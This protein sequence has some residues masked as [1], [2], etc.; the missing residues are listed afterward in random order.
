MEEIIT[1]IEARIAHLDNV[2]QICSDMKAASYVA[3]ATY[4]SVTGELYFLKQM[5]E[6]M[7]R[8]CVTAAT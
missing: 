5:S 1:E 7:R 8:L 4:N 6:K 3:E 2:L